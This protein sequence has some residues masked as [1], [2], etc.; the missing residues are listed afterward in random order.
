MPRHS[1]LNLPE[2][3]AAKFHMNHDACMSM[4]Q[5]GNASDPVTRVT[6]FAI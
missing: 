2:I 4:R 3:E 1:I 6:L 5:F